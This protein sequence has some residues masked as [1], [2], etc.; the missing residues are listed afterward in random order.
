MIFD[1]ASTTSR[2]IRL[3]AR[4]GVFGPDG[5]LANEH[6]YLSAE[7]DEEL[8]PWMAGQRYVEMRD[9]T[10]TTEDRALMSEIA[11]EVLSWVAAGHETATF[12]NKVN[13]LMQW[14]GIMDNSE[15]ADIDPASPLNLTFDMEGRPCSEQD[16]SCTICGEPCWNC[17]CDPHVVATARLVIA[18]F[19]G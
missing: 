19:G 16:G 5:E 18:P 13:L 10:M 8:R 4:V 14:D 1:R 12:P 17:T 6:T 11:D 7:V 2:P 9:G 15:S 3:E